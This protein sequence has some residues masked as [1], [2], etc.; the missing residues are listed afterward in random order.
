[1][2][3]LKQKSLDRIREKDNRPW[4]DLYLGWTYKGQPYLVRIRPQFGSEYSELVAVA[5][6]VP[7][8]EL[9]EKYL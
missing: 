4:I 6:E 1:M 2:K 5:E 3:L 8:G 9:L 7:S